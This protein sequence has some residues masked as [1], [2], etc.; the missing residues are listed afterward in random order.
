IAARAS[1]V[2]DEM[3]MVASTTLAELSGEV[4]D[5]SAIL[6]P[7]TVVSQISRRI[8]FAVARTAQQQGHALVTSEEDLL[9][10]IE[11]NFWTPEYREYR[12]V[13][14]RAR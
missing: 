2:T 10:A 14:M 13:A 4:E 7:L 11:R 9:A 12:R 8:A 6:P 1:R 3:L 5:A